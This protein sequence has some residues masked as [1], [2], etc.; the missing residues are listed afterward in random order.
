MDKSYRDRIGKKINIS[1]IVPLD[2]YKTKNEKKSWEYREYPQYNINFICISKDGTLGE[3]WKVGDLFIGLPSVEGK[4]IINAGKP[5]KESKWVREKPPVEF[6]KLWFKYKSEMGETHQSKSPEVR[7]RFVQERNELITKNIDFVNGE[8]DKREYGLFI[9]IDEEVHYFTGEY[10][11]FLSHYYLTESNMYGFFRTVAM[12]AL[13]HWEACKADTRVWGEIRGKGR[14]TSWSVESSSMALNAFT[15]TKF[16]KIPI[17][18]ERSQLAKELFQGKIVSSFEYYPI[19]F[20]PLINLPNSSVSSNLTVEFETDEAERSVI[21]HYPTK[22]T[23][24]DS[25]KVKNISINDEIGKWENE[26]LIDFISR[27]SRCHTEGGATGRFGSTAGEY[28]NGGGEEFEIEFM[29]ANAN[30]RNALGRTKNGLVSFFID[31]CYTMTQPVSYFDEWGYSIVNDPIEP[32][33]NE[34]G[35][36][37]S[38]GA[39]TDWQIVHDDLKKSGKKKAYNSFLRDMPR[40]LNHMF[41]NEGGTNNDF[42]INNLNE[43]ENYLK[44]IPSIEINEKIFRGNLIFAGEKFNSPVIW[45]P[46]DNGRIQT[47]WLPEEA[48]QNQ[49]YTKDFYGKKL[50]FPSNNHIGCFG[51]DSYDISKTVDDNGSN[52]A[53]V[54]YS[55]F[56]MAGAPSNSFFLKY[57]HRPDKRDDFYDDTI[58]MLQY[59]SMFALVENNKPRLLEYMKDY[60]YRGYS[61]TRPDKKWKDLSDFEKEHGGIP[62]SAQTNKDCASLHKDYILDFIGQNVEK[63]CNCYFIDMIQEWKKFDVNKRKKFD[64]TVAGELALMGSQYKVKQRKSLNI[65]VNNRTSFSFSDF[66]A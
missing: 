45:R 57:L 59:F 28:A 65:G 13:W 56:N 52:G 2:V 54:G 18:S 53:V 64:L 10:W 61:M 44:S 35:K 21:N 5:P 4:E 41:T 49:S 43:H 31:V 8:F 40:T 34:Q 7:K 26:S 58:C 33:I 63:E 11:M 48:L 25:T 1:D 42:D 9:K 14:R 20:K 15:I 19:Y 60:G 27:H 55:K 3:I 62:A 16:A 66:G 50:K 30:E 36:L 39:V 17:V 32:I 24:Y 51:V 12:E 38:I 23:A 37:I 22:T 47:T 29:S 46:N 6:R